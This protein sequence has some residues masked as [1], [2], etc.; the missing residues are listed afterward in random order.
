MSPTGHRSDSIDYRVLLIGLSLLAVGGWGV[1]ALVQLLGSSALDAEARERLF[2]QFMRV[3]SLR[4]YNTRIVLI[5]TT[6]L[7]AVSGIVGSFMLLRRRALVGDVVSHAGLPGIGIAFLLLESFAPH[8]GRSLPALLLGALV[9]GLSGMLCVTMIRRYTQIKEDAAL[10]IVLSVFFGLGVSLFTVIQNIP[11]GNVAGLQ[12]FIFGKAASLVASDVWLISLVAIGTLLVCMLLFKE[13][14]LLCFDDAYAA[15]EGWPIFWLDLCLMGLVVVV[16]VIGMQS[17]GLLLVVAL[18]IIP[19]AAAR[20]WSDRILAMSIAA[21]MI[22]AASGFLGTLLSAMFPRLATGA[23]IVLTSTGLFGVSML[24]SPHRGVLRRQLGRWSLQLRVRRQH[25][26][27]AC[28]EILEPALIAAPVNERQTLRVTWEQ[29]HTARGW[30][31]RELRLSIR[32]ALRNGDLQQVA[33][34]TYRMTKKGLAAAERI[35]RNHRMWE[36]YLIRSAD[37]APARVDRY[38]DLIEHELEPTVLRDLEQTLATR[39]PHLATTMP[40]SP[41]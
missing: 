17:V 31:L 12:G 26:L 27:R 28:Y 22:G 35:T 13:L 36:I 29:L 38:A 34:H 30:S 23:V 18:L 33:S 8:T 6:L 32:Q 40:S 41:H 16:T 9:A 15:S 4:D 25:L 2:E 20:F 1:I 24:I 39:F 11:S 7:G 10:A 5:G 14:T 21:A 37:V 3:V 19:A